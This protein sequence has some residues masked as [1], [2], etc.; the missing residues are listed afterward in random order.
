M[1]VPCTAVRQQGSESGR[2]S[3]ALA[4]RGTRLA[5]ADR[6]VERRPPALGLA[7]YR[8]P[9]TGPGARFA[10]AAVGAELVL[11][12]AAGAVGALVVAQRGAAGAD[13]VVENGLD[14]G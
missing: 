2:K 5:L 6:A 8:A 4:Q 14:L 12:Q 1:T 9:A 10:L 3:Q 7:P 11:E 13:G